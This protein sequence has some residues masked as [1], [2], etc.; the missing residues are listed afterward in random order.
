MGWSRASPPATSACSSSARPA[1]ARSGS[2]RPCT[3]ARARAGRPFLRLNCAALTETLLESELF[4]HEKGSFTGATAAKAGLLESAEGGTVF[5][6][7]VGDMPLTT[8]VK[9]LRVIE[10]QK[11]RRVG[12]VRP[13][14]IDVRFVSAT[15]RDL[16]LEVQRGTFRK[17]LF[18]RLNGISFV[19]PPLRERVAEIEPLARMLISDACR[20]MGRA[21]EPELTPEVLALLRQYPWPGNI[22]ELRNVIER[23]VLLCA[24]KRLA[25]SHLP[26]EKMSSHFAMRK[27]EQASP[28]PSSLFTMPTPPPPLLQGGPG[29]A[30]LREQLAQAERQRIV[31]AL[32]RC[33]GNQTEAA[34]SL[35]ISRRTLVKRLSTFNI[36]RPRKQKVSEP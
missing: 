30:E 20:R 4:G 2:P 28:A 3:R 31:D 19:I 1:W 7:E 25:L 33:A 36:P 29:P 15:N 5:L 14:E 34:I 13:T 22:R 11:V 12:A 27:P 6:D 21:E 10:E 35:G 26:A 17:D 8:Q 18:F 32:S 23:A 9:L 16:E 24:G